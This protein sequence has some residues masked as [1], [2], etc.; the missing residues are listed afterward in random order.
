VTGATGRIGGALVRRLR[1][2]GDEVLALGRSAGDLTADLSRPEAWRSL[3]PRLGRL[4]AVVHLAAIAHGEVADAERL[5]ATNTAG[6]GHV[7]DLAVAAG[8]ERFVLASTL[9][10]YAPRAL[11]AG[12]VDEAAAVAPATAYAR[13]KLAAEGLVLEAAERLGTA[14]ILRLA[15]VYSPRVLDDLRKRTVLAGIG[16]R[17]APRA[18]RFS[19][20]RLDNAVEAI[21]TV[22][23]SPPGG[24]QTYNAADAAP[25]TQDDVV[26]YLRRHGVAQPR[27]RLPLPPLAGP[28]AAALTRLL[29]AGP[30]LQ[31]LKAFGSVRLDVTKLA[32]LGYR[33]A[34]D[35]SSGAPLPSS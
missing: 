1:E 8:S 29:P 3:L 11:A 12:P 2:R 20:C 14:T 30:R 5:R 23:A 17:C 24:A 22:L 33:G 19:F 15:P 13:S 31:V 26:A 25:A 32:R 21:E 34:S 7:I 16:Y 35:L 6:T 28:G 18:A 10:V 9:D 4:D 27:F